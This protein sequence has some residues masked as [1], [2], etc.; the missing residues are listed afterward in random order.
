[1]AVRRIRKLVPTVE[2]AAGIALAIKTY[3]SSK[4]TPS[5][6]LKASDITCNKNTHTQAY[7]S[8]SLGDVKLTLCQYVPLGQ[9]YVLHFTIHS[10]SPSAESLTARDQ[11]RVRV[12][13]YM[14]RK[15]RK[16]PWHT[17]LMRICNFPTI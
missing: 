5:P 1:M 8:I 17:K 3:K 16:S 12:I 7:D 10:P 4:G 2:D 6:P 11:A 14:L 13:A 9:L 15:R